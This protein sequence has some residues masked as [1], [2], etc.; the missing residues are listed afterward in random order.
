MEKLKIEFSKQIKIPNFIQS[1]NNNFSI[2]N[3]F[4]IYFILLSKIISNDFEI[5]DE[6]NKFFLLFREYL[7]LVGWEMVEKYNSSQI[8]SFQLEKIFE[9]TEYNFISFLPDFLDNFL[10]IFIFLPDFEMKKDFDYYSDI[11]LNFSNWL[12]T[13]NLTNLKLKQ[14]G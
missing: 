14:Q 11:A 3:I 13:N 7:N 5:I 8:E 12:Y 1:K 9:F 2:I 6:L 4:A 10:R